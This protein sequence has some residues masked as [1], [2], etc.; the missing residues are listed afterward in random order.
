MLFELLRIE[1][2]LVSIAD[3]NTI[4]KHLFNTFGIFNDQTSFP[5]YINLVQLK[6]AI[7]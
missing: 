7:S 4:I 3:Q 2:K 1:F 5:A 6:F